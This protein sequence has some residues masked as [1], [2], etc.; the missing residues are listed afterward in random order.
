MSSH[1]SVVHL[2]DVKVPRRKVAKVKAALIQRFPAYLPIFNVSVLK[3]GPSLCTLV[4]QE[5]LPGLE[6][7]PTPTALDG[8]FLG[9][10][11]QGFSAD[12]PMTLL[13]TYQWTNTSAHLACCTSLLEE[14]YHT[15]RKVHHKD[16]Y[17][18]WSG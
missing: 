3:N 10:R 18:V 5:F 12:T 9:I 11:I 7:L 13:N 17:M 16:H 8:R 4:R 2:Q 1:P 15:A 14:V 6:K